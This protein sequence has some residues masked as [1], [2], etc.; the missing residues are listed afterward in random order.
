MKNIILF[1]FVVFQYTAF[2]QKHVSFD[3]ISKGVDGDKVIYAFYMKNFSND[4][5]SFQQIISHGKALRAKEP[6]LKVQ[7]LYW[8]EKCFS[9]ESYQEALQK[10]KSIVLK[11]ASTYNHKCPALY[12]KSGLLKWPIKHMFEGKNRY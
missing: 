7:S 9:F 8:V 6:Q 3:L 2:S 4:S 10:M 5:A 11:K 1:L 12:M